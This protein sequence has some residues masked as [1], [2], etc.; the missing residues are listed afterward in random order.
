MPAEFVEVN[1]QEL[2]FSKKEGQK[3]SLEVSLQRQKENFKEPKIFYIASRTKQ[4]NWI[5]SRC[6][7]IE[8]KDVARFWDLAFSF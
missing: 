5:T 1:L 2:F 6:E 7:K 8:N 4:F 3:K